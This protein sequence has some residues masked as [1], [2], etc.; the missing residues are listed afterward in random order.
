MYLC[1][2]KEKNMTPIIKN[3]FSKLLTVRDLAT[4]SY[5]LKSQ[6]KNLVKIL[7]IDDNDF[8]YE[9]EMRVCGFNINCVRDLEY[10]NMAEPY[11]IIISDITG[12]GKKLN[13]KYEGV[14]LINALKKQYPYKLYGVYTGNKV[15]IDIATV[16]KDVKIITKTGFD[17]DDWESLLDEFVKENNDPKTWWLKLRGALLDEDISLYELTLLEH[18][19]VNYILHNKTDFK[20]FLEDNL[21]NELKSVLININ[22][23]YNNSI[24]SIA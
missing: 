19:Y 23:N 9:N 5:Q 2:K 11:H 6:N 20:K 1:K 7:I 3:P 18:K 22:F 13:C 17:K 15:S 4:K 12:V 16:L 10:F 24:L 21:S 14:G 8:E